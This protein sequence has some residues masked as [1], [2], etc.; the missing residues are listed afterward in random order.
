MY[1][2]LLSFAAS[3]A[4]VAMADAQQLAGSEWTPTEIAGA[5]QEEDFDVFVQF[6]S[7]NRLSG[8]GGCNRIS[9]SYQIAGEEL[10]IGSV[11]MTR[12][13]CPP[14]LMDR[15]KRFVSALEAAQTYLRQKTVLTLS[16]SD[17]LILMKLRQTDWD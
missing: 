8:S 17:G 2:V 12:R 13:L 14:P 9:G 10:S 6:G 16:G 1:G 5:P 11:A 4:V 15:E 7:E 3:F